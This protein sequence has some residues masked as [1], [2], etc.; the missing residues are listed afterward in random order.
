VAS[1]NRLHGLANSWALW[2]SRNLKSI[3]T[4]WKSLVDKS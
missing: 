1:N 2:A 3:T 4:T